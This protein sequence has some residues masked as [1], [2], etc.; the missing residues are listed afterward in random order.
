MSVILNRGS[1]IAIM[2]LA[3]CSGPQQ[4]EVDSQ[5]IFHQQV[6]VVTDYGDASI[7][8]YFPPAEDRLYRVIFNDDCVSCVRAAEA[9]KPSTV[10]ETRVCDFQLTASGKVRPSPEKLSGILNI[11]NVTIQPKLKSCS[12]I[13]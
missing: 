8:A 12:K 6:L 5:R 9:I 11:G 1:I 4:E 10:Y 3:S 13:E 7:L 2:L